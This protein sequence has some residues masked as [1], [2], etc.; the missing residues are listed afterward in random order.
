MGLN[1][2]TVAKCVKIL[3]TVL[4]MNELHPSKWVNDSTFK[5]TPYEGVVYGSDCKY[6]D[7][8]YHGYESIFA[9]KEGKLT[10]EQKQ[11]FEKLC[12]KIPNTSFCEIYQ[13][14]KN[15]TILGWF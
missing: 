11:K 3:N 9:F 6:F 15:F 12:E 14:N 5:E 1:K 10:P 4:E 8:K 7:G 13:K 2:E